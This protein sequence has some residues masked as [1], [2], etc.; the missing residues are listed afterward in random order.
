META[1]KK[2]RI[3]KP[4]DNVMVPVPY[5][6]RAMIDAY[7]LHIVIVEEFK[8]GTRYILILVWNKISKISINLDTH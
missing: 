4:G 2:I 7:S 5:L 8:L 6:D 1:A 3:V